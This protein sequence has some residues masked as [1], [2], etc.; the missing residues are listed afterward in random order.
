M[1]EESIDAWLDMLTSRPRSAQLLRKD[2]AIVRSLEQAMSKYL[3]DVSLN[4]FKADKR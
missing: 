3:K 4:S 1:Q 2:G